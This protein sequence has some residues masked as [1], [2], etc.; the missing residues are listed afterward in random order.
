MTKAEVVAAKLQEAIATREQIVRDS[1]KDLFKAACASD[2]M[3][4]LGMLADDLDS[5]DV[6]V[7]YIVERCEAEFG[8][9]FDFEE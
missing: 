8:L 4:T 5:G 1:G 2:E 9:D 3:E 6:S 7:E